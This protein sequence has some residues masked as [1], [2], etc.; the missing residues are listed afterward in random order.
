MLST[1][2]AALT[3]QMQEG[4]DGLVVPRGLA[5]PLDPFLLGVPRFARKLG[6]EYTVLVPDNRWVLQDDAAW[7]L[8]RFVL[9]VEPTWLRPGDYVSVGQ[10]EM[11]QVYDVSGP[12]VL[13]AT[14]L[15]ADHDAG[16]H[17]YHHSAVVI[18]EGTYTTGQTSINIDM[19]ATWF[20]TV[21][22][23][24]AVLFNLEVAA[25]S[26]V[27]YTV[28]SAR[29]IGITSAVSQ[30]FVTLDRELHR[31][32]ADGEEIQL[33]AYPAYQSRALKVPQS[34]VAVIGIVG[35]YL[36]DW[37]SVPFV[38]DLDPVEYQTVQYLDETL[39]PTGTPLPGSKNML[40]LDAVIRADQFMFWDQVAGTLDF[41]G[42][43]KRVLGRRDDNGWWWLKYTCAPLIAVPTTVPQGLIVTVAKSSLL[44]LDSFLLSDDL[45]TV[46]FE[47]QVD[48][49]YVATPETA[50]SGTVT[51]A[52]L[53]AG[54]PLDNDTLVLDN[55]L[56][57]V[58]TFEFQR[59]GAFVSAASSYRIID[60][61]AA[62]LQVDVAVAIET[63]VMAVRS[64]L[65]IAAVNVGWVVNLTND[66]VTQRGNQAVVVTGA[67][68]VAA[69]MAAGT[70]HRITIDL[71]LV[72]TPI[73]VALLTAAAIN[74]SDLHVEAHATATAPSVALTSTIPGP[75][76]NQP[77]IESVVAPGFVTVGMQGGG[78][79]KVWAFHAQC[80]VDALLR[81]RFYPNGWQD[82][83]LVAGVDAAIAVQLAAT[84]L[85][86]ERIDLLVV[87]DDGSAG[88]EFQMTSWGLRDSRVTALR[89]T[90]V[91]RVQGGRT[92]CCTGLWAKPLWRSFDDLKLA[93]NQGY[94]NT[95]YALL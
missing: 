27:E 83:H 10:R 80:E 75:A 51:I 46:R 14:R 12:T 62:A 3:K 90:Y 53:P 65:G 15:L 6:F 61:Q 18:V 40:V 41:N 92:F 47:Y 71:Q 68:G 81:V 4:T 31:G 91:V 82:F 79:G 21:G 36:L 74:H 30:W 45:D 24:I 22:D 29:L 66:V 32:L 60:V 67:W 58:V 84:D 26:F 37:T 70:H 28:V 1:F 23:V 85:P 48:A 57:T 55:G 63:A 54:I 73:D 7:N 69:G 9:D 33:R 93:M 20:C 86:V 16:T 59:T 19:P 76:G 39:V 34:G 94:L 50:A 13:L 17:V 89:H 49:T 38:E 77:I 52:A 8:D 95:G 64:V 42:T 72:T 56:G 87:A 44:N 11:H 35:P 5:Y 78:G 88:G 2:Q 25:P 43:T